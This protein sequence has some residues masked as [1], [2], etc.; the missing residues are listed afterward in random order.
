MPLSFVPGSGLTPTARGS[1]HIRVVCNLLI[2]NVA[3]VSAFRCGSR[4]V[5]HRVPAQ[6]DTPQWH[7]ELCAQQGWQAIG[8]S[9]D[10]LRTEGYF[11][12]SEVPQ[13]PST[14]AGS[15]TGR[16]SRG[17]S[18]R[19][20]GPSSSRG[21]GC[22][23]QGG[24]GK[25]SAVSKAADKARLAALMAVRREVEAA[26]GSWDPVRGCAV[27][28]SRAVPDDDDI[29]CM[30]ESTRAEA[31]AARDAAAKDAAFDLDAEV[32]A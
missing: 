7:Q 26:G 13:Q 25:K 22:G 21:R 27:G 6:K 16:G 3:L 28:S 17:P 31:E 1:T 20:S 4:R 24:R 12:F 30:G 29:E 32:D 10:A 19:G 8:H 14:A 23:G 5:A 11:F 18:S 2:H 9:V 15:S